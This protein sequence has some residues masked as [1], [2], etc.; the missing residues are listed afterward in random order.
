MRP[1]M[2]YGMSRGAR[3]P[4]YIGTAAA[5]ICCLFLA[6]LVAAQVALALP[7]WR[8]RLSLVDALEGVRVENARRYR[9]LPSRGRL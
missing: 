4:D 5:A 7:T 9:G 6:A 2:I 3:K 8:A 1:E